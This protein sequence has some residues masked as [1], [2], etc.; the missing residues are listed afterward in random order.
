ME[1]GAGSGLCFAHYPATV[2]EVMAVEPEPY[3]R[4]LAHRAASRAP[5]PVQ[6]TGGNADQ[7]PFD[8]ESFDDVVV[9][10]VLC[11][12]PDPHRALN[13]AHRILVP[14]GQLRFYEHVRSEQ[15][16]QAR[17]QDRVEGIWRLIAGAV[18]Q[19][20]R[21]K[22]QYARVAFASIGATTSNSGPDPSP[23]RRLP[24]SSEGPSGSD[25]RPIYP[26]GPGTGRAALHICGRSGGQIRAVHARAH[27]LQAAALLELIEEYLQAGVPVCGSRDP[28]VDGQ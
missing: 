21:P 24:I 28:V 16:R 14:H 13:E 19:T 18:A 5:V 1:I 6:V 23:G 22:R 8:D 20:A 3:L 27:P 26:Q 4:R 9:S 25:D 11:S 10:L 12:V 17:T 15:A 7:L 2:T